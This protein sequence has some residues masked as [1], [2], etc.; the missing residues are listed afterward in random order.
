MQHLPASDIPSVPPLVT[1]HAKTLIPAVGHNT[2]AAFIHRC[3]A[4]ECAAEHPESLAFLT[5]KACRGGKLLICPHVY[6]LQWAGNQLH[7]WFTA[8]SCTG[9]VQVVDVEGDR[10]AFDVIGETL[11]RTN[12]GRLEEGSEVNFER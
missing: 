12:L 1:A 4:K 7:K 5:C 2:R 6:A 10:A 3:V 11:S 8:L 9:V